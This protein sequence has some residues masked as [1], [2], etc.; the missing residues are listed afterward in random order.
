MIVGMLLTSCAFSVLAAPVGYVMFV[1]GAVT[2]QSGGT[3]SPVRVGQSIEVGDRLITAEGGYVHLKMIDEAFYSLRPNSRFFIEEYVYDAVQS[4][5]NRVKTYLEAGS[6]RAITGKAGETHKQG[7]RLN[8]PVAAIGVRGTDYIVHHVQE[9]TRVAVSSGA[10]VVSS[11]NDQC[12]A[13]S[14]GA[15]MGES[16]LLLTA[17]LT[18]SYI[19]VKAN[20]PIPELKQDNWSPQ[21]NIDVKTKYVTTS[22]SPV[23]ENSR[24]D[25]G[26]IDAIT[27]ASREPVSVEASHEPV[28]VARE[29]VSVEAS[30]FNWGR[31]QNA[32]GKGP[33]SDATQAIRALNVGYWLTQSRDTMGMGYPNI[34]KADFALTQSEAAFR[35][36][37]GNWQSA[38][39]SKGVLGVDFAQGTFSTQLSGNFANQQPWQV[40]AMGAV[41]PNGALMS[42]PVKSDANTW[43]EGAISSTASQAAYIFDK[44]FAEGAL[45]GVTHW[46][47]IR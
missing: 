13:A 7:Y 23:V 11:F 9:A 29:P 42:N 27:L 12:T 33:F 47:K 26:S 19:E 43:V 8:T 15:C 45:V 38:S 20:Q 4:D 3:E 39:V 17:N 10:V 2:L 22:H 30:A 1:S 35:Q 28:S 6:V 32:D 46:Y 18:G 44:R 25:Q 40:S 24:I 41:Q 34:S 21:A 36:V 16:S 37:D 31:W 5:K 14:L